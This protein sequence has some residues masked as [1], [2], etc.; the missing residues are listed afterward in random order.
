MHDE[1]V[2]V[3]RGRG[4]E[5]E[6]AVQALRAVLLRL[7]LGDVLLETG[8]VLRGEAAL[9]AAVLGLGPLG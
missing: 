8:G 2:A 6:A 9:G 5:A 4:R 7:V 3:E 1:Q